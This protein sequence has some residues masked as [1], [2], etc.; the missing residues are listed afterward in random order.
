MQPSSLRAEISR[1]S[2]SNLWKCCKCNHAT[3]IAFISGEHPIG[4]AACV[5]QHSLCHKCSFSG[6]SHFIPIVEPCLVPVR[7]SAVLAAFEEEVPFGIICRECGLSW[8]T[9]E[10]KA[11]LPD[12]K[13]SVQSVLR[14]L[15]SHKIA[16]TAGR[17]R[18]S[19]SLIGPGMLIRE[20]KEKGKGKEAYETLGFKNV[21]FSGIP[22][23]CSC[24][25]SL[26]STF[27]FRIDVSPPA[28][29]G[30]NVRDPNEEIA[31]FL[32]TGPRDDTVIRTRAGEHPNPLK[33]APVTDSDFF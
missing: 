31:G 9:T 18:K 17:L 33:S 29:P 32:V 22:C 3:R 27:C 23:S 12:R 30:V 8:R 2:N 24:V 13:T 7:S 26:D 15:R 11:T 6:I 1:S 25:S 21:T 20:D 28:I 14:D 4:T 5:C 10:K 16:P 19:R